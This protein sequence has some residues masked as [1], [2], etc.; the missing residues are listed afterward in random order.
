MGGL[1]GAFVPLS[2]RDG[3]DVAPDPGNAEFTHSIPDDG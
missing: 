1:F 3:E 2:E